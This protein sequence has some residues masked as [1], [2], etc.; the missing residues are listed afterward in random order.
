[1][2]IV[3]DWREIMGT[4]PVS[5]FGNPV[6]NPQNLPTLPT[7]PSSVPGSADIAHRNEKAVSEDSAPHATPNANTANG[8]PR[9]RAVEAD[10]SGLPSPLVD[11]ADAISA[12]PRSPIL[13]DLALSRAAACFIAAERA[14][15]AAPPALR[16]EIDQIAV[17]AMSFAAREIRR[18]N[19]QAA[20]D[21]LDILA[22]K[23]REL[24]AH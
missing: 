12:V 7:K 17:D 4:P 9:A 23:V 13:N 19:Y 20:Y 1:M 2:E 21:A 14:A 6:Q 15:Q 16:A 18:S 22:G 8:N 3:N 10:Y 5:A 11:I 24:R